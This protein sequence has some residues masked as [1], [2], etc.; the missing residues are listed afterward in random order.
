MP[1]KFRELGGMNAQLIVLS[2]ITFLAAVAFGWGNVNGLMVFTPLL[3]YIPIILAA[4]WFPRQGVIFAVIVGILE[5]FS[6]YLFSATTVNEVTFAVTTASFYILVAVAV[7]ISSLS[8][9]IQE[10][11]ARYRGIFNSSEAGIFILRNGDNTL[12][13][14][15]ANPRG[16]AL[17][18]ATPDDIMGKPFVRFWRDEPGRESFFKALDANG[19]APQKES[20]LTRADGVPIP[21]LV[22]GARLPGQ[23]IVLMVVDISARITQENELRARN[24]QLALINRIIADTSAATRPEVLADA[25]LF[26]LKDVVQCDSSG[27]YILEAAGKPR[28]FWTGDTGLA[29]VLET[30]DSATSVEWRDAVARGLPFVF[31]ADGDT[32]AGFPREIRVHPLES[33]GQKI[34]VLCLLSRKQMKSLPGETIEM[35]CREIANAMMRVFLFEK[36]AETSRQANLYIDILMHDINN[37]NL[38]SLWYGDLLL[39]MLS[40]EQ[41]EMARKVIEGIKKSREIIRNVETIRKIHGRQNNLRPCDLD[42]AIRK[43]IS[44]FPDALIEY[45]GRFVL[46][47][48]DDLLGEIFSNLIGNSIKFGGP[49][50]RISISIIKPGPEEVVVTVSDNCPGIPDD[51]KKVIFKRFSSE[52]AGE[53]GKGLGLYIVKKLISR[54]GGTIKVTDRVAGDHTQGTTFILRFRE[55]TP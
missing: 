40:G 52:K 44:L 1:G 24:E 30:S 10:K 8:G 33:Q 31:R 9:G 17:L 12:A 53:T 13:I 35:L 55:A 42:Q 18:G 49:D 26:H 50:V 32:V 15:E 38:A 37:A 54:Y 14:E 43:E 5:V 7:V 22:S 6:V 27:I 28:W 39:E 25:V 23:A 21:V 19:L 34:G 51:L 29:K 2:F 48:A 3:F 20:S 45:S 11:D 47:W 4:Y 36:L 46:V 16:G 41:K